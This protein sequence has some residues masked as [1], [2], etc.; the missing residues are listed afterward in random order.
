MHHRHASSALSAAR[1]QELAAR[2][3]SEGF[4]KAAVNYYGEQR[5]MD[6]VRNNERV[7]IIDALLAGELQTRLQEALGTDFPWVIEG[8]RFAKLGAHLRAYRYEP[9][10]YFKPHRDGSYEDAALGLSSMAT[11]LFYLNDCD[12]GETALMPYGPG[13]AWAHVFIEPKAGDALVFEHRMWH[14]GK[15]V[16]SG[17][18]LVLRADLFYENA[19]LDE[20]G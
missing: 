5:V 8:R 2:A 15:P 1:C 13:Q 9:G 10:Q 16:R 7:E 3:R 19:P 11:A 17:E 12:G 14:E 6:A 4:E 20:A 18:K